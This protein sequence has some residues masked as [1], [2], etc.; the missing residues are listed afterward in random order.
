MSQDAVPTIETPCIGV[1]T[2]DG[3]SDICLGCL[4]SVAEIA[5]WRRMTPLERTAVMADLPR[6]RAL[7]RPE[8]PEP[9][10]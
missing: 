5:R 4:R 1:C 10:P 9:S 6:R 8:A 3:E 7:L 2:L